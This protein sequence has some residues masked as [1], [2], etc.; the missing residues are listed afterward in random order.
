MVLV[1]P[2]RAAVHAIGHNMLGLSRRAA[3][4][5]A[6]RAQAAAEAAAAT[7]YG[8]LGA[9]PMARG[10]AMVEGRDPRGR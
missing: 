9:L 3:A 2:G 4:A 10:A 5:T 7:Q 6:G 8:T 1:R